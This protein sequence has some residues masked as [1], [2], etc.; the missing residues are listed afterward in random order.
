M[1][2]RLGFTALQSAAGHSDIPHPEPVVRLRDFTRRFGPNTIIDGLDLDIAPG[3]FI[4]LLG[5]SG[6]GKTTL[7]RTLA[8]LDEV[9]GQDVE[10]PDSRAVVFQDARLLPWK[11][12]WKNVALGLKGDRVRDRSEAALKEVGLGHRL[13][14]WPLTLSGGEAQRVALARALVREP[15]LLLLDE[16]FAALD[17]LT[18]YRMHDLVL[19]LWR[20]HRPAV[21]IVTHDVEE[22][23]ALADRVLVLD[24]GRIVA[25]ER[26]AVP[27]GERSAISGRLREKLLSYL[28]G[29]DHGEGVVPFAPIAEAAE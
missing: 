10:V 3:E 15:K 16:P 20:A 14:A 2:A 23:I 18:R 13:D 29:E 27:R 5:R 28:G 25:Q 26:I 22:A 7:L 6:S 17:A 12:V 8:G 24:K 21:L 4:A 1:D 19:S 9:R 11:P